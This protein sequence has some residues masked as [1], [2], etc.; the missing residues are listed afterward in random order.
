PPPPSAVKRIVLYIQ[1]KIAIVA[2]PSSY[3]LSRTATIVKRSSHL[4][5]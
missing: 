3:S 2:M 4:S 5:A 1:V